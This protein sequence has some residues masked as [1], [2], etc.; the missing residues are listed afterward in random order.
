MGFLSEKQRERWCPTC[1]VNPTHTNRG[2][3]EP[4]RLYVSDTRKD[5]VPPPYTHTGYNPWLDPD[6]YPSVKPPWGTLNAIDLNTGEY[7]WKVPLGEYPE[8]DRAGPP[9]TGHAE[10]R[11]ARRDRGRRAG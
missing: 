2:S 8:T 4:G 6:G 5:A 1:W 10:L 9:P 11:R 7:L 3:R